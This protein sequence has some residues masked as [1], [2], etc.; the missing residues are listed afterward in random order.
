MDNV[1]LI[2]SPS[3]WSMTGTP[4]S[5]AM[6]A[7]F[8]G[9]YF[10]AKFNGTGLDIHVDTAGL[11]EYPWV[12]YRIDNGADSINKLTPGQ[13][14]I[15]IAGLAAGDHTVFVFYHARNNY[16]QKDT[17]ADAQKL[18][19][20]SVTCVGGRGILPSTPRPLKGI[21]YGDSITAGLACGAAPGV[22]CDDKH[23][24]G[25][26][27][28]YAYF[29]GNGLNAEYDQA[30]CGGDGWTNGGV[31][32]F[33]CFRDAWN[34]KKAGVARDLSQHDF[35]TI[36]HGYNDG[37]VQDSV[38]S[39][40]MGKLRAANANMW[41]F[42]MVP[43]SGRNKTAIVNGVADY[44][45]SHPTERKIKVIDTSGVRI[46]TSDGIHPTPAGGETL[47]NFMVS[48]IKGHLANESKPEPAGSSLPGSTSQKTSG[49]ASM[50][51]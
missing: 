50:P 24:N 22:L 10:R 42:P 15:R 43:F 16:N 40:M 49:S 1:N 46:K 28:S 11:L 37:K 8:V 31:G 45:S 26:T 12:G 41:I 6:E 33:P 13:K 25:S 4:G 29:L 9:S 38:V 23:T 39:S 36:Y 30:G 27:G 20:L 18:R 47:A 51:R 3:N 14:V 32:G 35:V 44:L 34:Y 17:W 19:I 48:A 2:K 5:M 7:V 21:L